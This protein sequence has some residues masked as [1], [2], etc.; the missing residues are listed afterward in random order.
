M[1]TELHSKGEPPTEHKLVTAAG[2]DELE[3]SSK[4]A[5]EETAD[6]EAFL[7]RL[8]ANAA[9]TVWAINEASVGE[10]PWSPGETTDCEVDDETSIVSVHKITEAESSMAS[11]MGA[12]WRLMLVERKPIVNQ[13]KIKHANEW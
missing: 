4:L 3:T 13:S 2:T 11:K 12:V 8:A 1:L 5:E 7:N 6:N 10:I 9:C